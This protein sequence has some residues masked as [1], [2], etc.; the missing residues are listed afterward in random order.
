MLYNPKTKSLS[1]AW[2]Q[3]FDCFVITCDITDI[4]SLLGVIEKECQTFMPIV[5]HNS[6]K[7]IFV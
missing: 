7:I 2:R 5:S 6:V 3:Y 1:G 4:F